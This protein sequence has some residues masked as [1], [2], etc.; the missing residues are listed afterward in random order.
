MYLSVFFLFYLL[1]LN[2]WELPSGF[3][4]IGWI[5]ASIFVCSILFMRSQYSLKYI[6]IIFL[7]LE[8]IIF[9]YNEVSG[10]NDSVIMGVND[11]TRY[12]IPKA[13]LLNSLDERIQY[14]FSDIQSGKLTHVILSMYISLINIFYDPIFLDVILRVTFVFNIL[15]S[16]LTIFIVHKAAIIYSGNILY[17]QRAAW[18]VALNPYF[19]LEVGEAKKEAILSLAIVLFILFI[20]KDKWRSIWL[21]LVS[22]LIIILDRLYMIPV[23][24]LTWLLFKKRSSMIILIIA[25]TSI[26]FA[27][28]IIGFENAFSIIRDHNS[29]L[30]EIGGSYLPAHNLY[31]DILRAIFSPFFIRGFYGNIVDLTF[32]LSLLTITLYPLLFYKML[33]HYKGL[34]K[35]ISI[36]FIYLV[37]FFPIQSPFKML[38]MTIL[39]SMVLEHISFVKYHFNYRKI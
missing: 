38:M 8:I 36:L 30:T 24:L 10:I 18:F 34:A 23:L 17:A 28:Y 12:H 13:L 27:E 15:I 29:N 2:D 37:C 4:V 1:F 39:G 35:S 32:G 22:S 21:L 25:V 16:T 31:Y 6:I 3:I 20:V 33:F 5:Y 14:M 9:F 7:S 19:L 11:V 26:F